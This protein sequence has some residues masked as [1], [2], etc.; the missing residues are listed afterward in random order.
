[1]QLAREG[2]KDKALKLLQKVEKE[3][4]AV[5][6]NHTWHS[7]SPEIARTWLALGQPSKAEE[8]AEQLGN[9]ACE[10]LDW[11]LSLPPRYAKMSTS[12]VRY[13]F[14]QLQEVKELLSAADSKKAAKYEKA[15]EHY[16]GMMAYTFE[17]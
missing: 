13:Y 2:K 7:G 15:I 6:V 1:M 4:P 5:T 11:Y 8:I 12:D 3:I 14:Y 10:Y 9:T 17:R 16:Y